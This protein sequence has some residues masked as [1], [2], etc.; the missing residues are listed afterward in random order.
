M[1]ASAA[2]SAWSCVNACVSGPALSGPPRGVSGPELRHSVGRCAAISAEAGASGPGPGLQHSD[3]P[4]SCRAAG[5]EG[6]AWLVDS[7]AVSAPSRGGVKGRVDGDPERRGVCESSKSSPWAS[8]PRPAP[9]RGSAWARRR[10]RSGDGPAERGEDPGLTHSPGD[11]CSPPSSE[12][13]PAGC[14]RSGPSSVLVADNAHGRSCGGGAPGL[15]RRVAP[16]GP[17][18]ERRKAERGPAIG[19]GLA[20]GARTLAVLVWTVRG[21]ARSSARRMLPR[22][23]SP[24]CT[25]T[26]SAAHL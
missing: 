6:A 9:T 10:R 5:A 23:A 4:R 14:E 17:R 24:V 22:T 25:S 1:A 16:T 15:T 12:S 19:A 8:S 3:R 2:A 18:P 7:A 11:C 20:S 26:L 13:S 21:R